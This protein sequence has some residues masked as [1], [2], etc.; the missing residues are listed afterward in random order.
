MIN[1]KL[2]K[3]FSIKSKNK[4]ETLKL[5]AQGKINIKRKKMIFYKITINEILTSNND[6]EYYNNTFEN[7]FF[8]KNVLV[9][10]V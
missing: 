5:N 9:I 4:N 1:K 10:L 8:D 3:K 2:L 7:I 6:L